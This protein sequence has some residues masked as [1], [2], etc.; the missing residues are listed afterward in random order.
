MSGSVLSLYSNDSLKLK[1]AC[2]LLE[3][4]NNDKINGAKRDFTY[5][6][7]FSFL[8]RKIGPELTSIANLLFA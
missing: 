7:F 8:V 3:H 6:L 1:S 5:I 2:I 4:S